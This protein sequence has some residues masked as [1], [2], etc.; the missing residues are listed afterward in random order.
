MGLIRRDLNELRYNS[1]WL[2]SKQDS[3]YFPNLFKNSKAFFYGM[4]REDLVEELDKM[5]KE[6]IEDIMGADIEMVLYVYK[7]LPF[8]NAFTRSK[9]PLY[10]DIDIY[11]YTITSWLNE[12]ER[13][14]FQQA[15]TLEGQIRFSLPSR[16]FI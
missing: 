7:N 11:K 16:Q 8:I 12:I 6:K 4:G 2:L 1:I 13:F 5:I 3:D 9:N 15:V 10:A 14:I